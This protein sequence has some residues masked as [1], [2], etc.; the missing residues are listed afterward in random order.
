MERKGEHVVKLLDE[1]LILK[2]TAGRGRVSSLYRHGLQQINHTPEDG[3]IPKIIGVS[4]I[5][6]CEFKI[7]S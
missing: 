3:Q 1:E 5:A 4:Q 2:V 7:K 6:H